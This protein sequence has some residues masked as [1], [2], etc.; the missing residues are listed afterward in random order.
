[1]SNEKLNEALGGQFFQGNMGDTSNIFDYQQMNTG[2]Q[3]TTVM[4]NF[5]LAPWQ[6]IIANRIAN[7]HD[8]LVNVAPAA[9]KTIPTLSGW[10]TLLFSIQPNQ[11]VTDCPKLLW[12]VPT[13]QLANQIFIDDF[14]NLFFNKHK[15]VI[16]KTNRMRDRTPQNIAQ[17][18]RTEL[19]LVLYTKFPQPIKTK[20]EQGQ[21]LL[22]QDD[23]EIRT[24]I[25]TWLF[26]ISGSG[27]VG[28]PNTAIAF[29]CTEEIAPKLIQS[30]RNLAVVAIDEMQETFPKGTIT[31]KQYEIYSGQ[32]LQKKAINFLNIIDATPKPGRC[33][34]AL[35]T[36]S[37]NSDTT[38]E[39][40]KYINKNFK[41]NLTA[42][43]PR[44]STDPTATNRSNI[45]L[46]IHSGM[47]TIDQLVKLTKAIIDEKQKNSLMIMFS[48]GGNINTSSKQ[49]S[50]F[51]I[52]SELQKRLPHIYKLSGYET[53]KS[54]DLTRMMA[55]Q[56]LQPTPQPDPNQPRQPRQLPWPYNEFKLMLNNTTGRDP[57]LA[58][59]L[60]RGFGYFM[61]GT[62]RI[63]SYQQLGIGVDKSAGKQFSGMHKD[64]IQLIQKMFKDG[65]IY[66]IL[67]TD[68]VG[69][70]ANLSVKHLYLPSLN[71]YHGPGQGPGGATSGKID[72][73]SLVQLIN[74][75]GRQFGQNATIYTTKDNY[76]RIYEFL[77]NDPQ[78]QIAPVDA[79]G[80]L[81]RIDVFSRIYKKMKTS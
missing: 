38:N 19:P 49:K 36:G 65:L 37:M 40:L 8:V 74:R 42:S 23:A 22:P 21:P 47:E 69:V 41:R 53:D 57:I 20:I 52:C 29:V 9:G 68:A 77:E 28:N 79:V 45:S 72:D 80:L 55:R 25:K 58:D 78:S 66:L 11:P 2:T 10:Y 75:A 30:I 39:L 81:N 13:K 32:D 71:K 54:G 5:T 46:K 7:R 34:L 31:D 6:Q 3:I 26:H 35:L 44:P 27:K 15:S 59:C 61:G 24:L 16:E 43:D 12:V 33:A 18:I 60:M 70:G 48:I 76:D 63:A 67:A 50:I 73:S 17:I 4:N 56:P 62:A 1:M 51:G 14:I 64:D